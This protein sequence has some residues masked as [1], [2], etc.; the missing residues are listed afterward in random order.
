[1]SYKKKDEKTGLLKG[2]AAA[3]YIHALHFYWNR[4]ISALIGKDEKNR[5]KSINSCWT[6]LKFT[7]YKI[8]SQS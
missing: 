3:F 2:T 4:F 7:A 5:L 8:Y 6:K 1:M